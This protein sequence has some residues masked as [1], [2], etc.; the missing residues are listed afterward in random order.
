MPEQ[1]FIYEH[2][3]SESISCAGGKFHK[4]TLKQV[5]WFVDRAV[6]RT[7]LNG[8]CGVQLLCLSEC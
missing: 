8:H 5:L 4:Y 2:R 1:E 7:W 3:T 6:A